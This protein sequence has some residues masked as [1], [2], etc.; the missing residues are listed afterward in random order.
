MINNIIDCHCTP[1]IHSAIVTRSWKI[2]HFV[3]RE[4][5]R[6]Q[7]FILLCGFAA[8]KI[9]QWISGADWYFT[10]CYV[11]FC[12]TMSYFSWKYLRC[13][14]W[15]C[16]WF[17]KI[18]SH[19]SHVLVVMAWGVLLIESSLQSVTVLFIIIAGEI[20]CCVEVLNLFCLYS[21]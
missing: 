16:G 3:T 10:H 14:M 19:R 12:S 2:N 6:T 17:S 1:T 5:N 7:Y 9:F 13:Q 21:R 15:Q 20:N 8:I 4:I 11:D 18:R